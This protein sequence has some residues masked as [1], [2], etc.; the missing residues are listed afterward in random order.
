MAV[1]AAV[2]YC[3]TNHLQTSSII[4]DSRSVLLALANVNTNSEI[5]IIKNKIR[6]YNGTIH[7]F[8]IKAH[9]GF[10]G[11]EKAD[12][13]AKEATRK[14]DVD[15]AIQYNTLFVKNIMKKEILAEWQ[16]RS[17]DS[18][19]GR[20]VFSILPQVKTSRVQGDFYL[21]QLLTGHGALAKY[22]ARFFGK[23]SSC[24]CGH[25]IEDRS[26]L[27]FDCPQW[28][29]IR[30]KYFPPC[31]R[32]SDIILLIKKTFE[33][34]LVQPSERMQWD[35]SHYLHPKPLRWLNCRAV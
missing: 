31:F 2:D 13:Y 22:Q 10:A 7:L 6:N 8:W 33:L 29:T 18:S 19:K 15:I 26:H 5:S 21:N 4:T 23:E 24:Q 16:R 32:D 25:P 9:V 14:P 3:I 20:E 11:N 34:T 27:I 30:K 17:D 1:N 28:H 12:E 35:S